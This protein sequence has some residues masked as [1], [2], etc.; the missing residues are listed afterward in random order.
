[1][2]F[3]EKQQR[4]AENIIW[5]CAQSHS[6]SPDFKAYD[7]EGNADVY[8]NC[9]IGFVRKYYDYEK[10]EAVLRGIQQY[11]EAEVYEGLFWLGLEN[12]SYYKEVSERPV[13][14]SLR[15]KYAERYIEQHNSLNNYYILD[16]LS[17][18]HWQ[19][20][21]GLDDSLSAYDK[22]LL[23]E[24]EFSSELSTDEIVERAGKLF[25]KWFQIIAEEKK[26]NSKK[27]ILPVFSLKRR[28]N[29]TGK[30]KYI[31]FGA[32]FAFHPENIY[33]GEAVIAEAGQLTTKLSEA[34]LREFME[35]KYGRPIFSKSKV[36]D[37]ERALCRDNHENCHLLFTDGVRI[38]ESEIQNGF[39][40]LSRQREKA[41]IKLNR[42]YYDSNIIRN[43]L[44]VSRLSG[45]IRN[46]VLLYMQPENI[47]SNTGILNSPFAWRAGIFDDEKVFVKSEN[48]NLG[49]LSVDILLDASTSQKS[50]QE[51]ISSQGYIICESLT[52]CGIPCR[53][54]S[55]CSMTG[56]TVLRVFRDYSSP[57]DNSKIFEYVSNG[58]N[59]DG[60]AIRAAHYL[61]NSSP[62]EH[63][64]LIV[65]SDVKPNDVIKIKK[66]DEEDGVP[67][68]AVSG[69][70][71]TAVEVRRA[72]ND[73]ISVICVFTGDDEELPSAR[74][75]YDSAFVRI[76]SFA[77]LAD[78]VG[79]LIQSQIKNL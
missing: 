29:K 55:F 33:G 51:I 41:Q 5:T 48:D 62:Y 54:M 40:A 42:E 3:S 16:R 36:H 34:Q 66:P 52:Q 77:S 58:C 64:L 57:K 32:G 38:D 68:D 7:L 53:V 47:K 22:L 30:E 25:L 50:R 24:L 20:A 76:K 12:S 65:L 19:R 60:L 28:V 27:R 75:V 26:K 74:L 1:M 11:E 35:T 78:T 23:D 49:N 72:R 14:V 15:K 43:R 21:S 71:D 61:M 2:I 6:F 13:L 67:Y 31:R 56:Y 45:N 69:L 4:R 44:A 17:F 63:K 70:D 37:V 8:F 9:I 73:G 59:R 39:E 10:I 79:K 46:S 18:A